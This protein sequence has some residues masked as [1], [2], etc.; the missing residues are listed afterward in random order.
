[1]HWHEEES[2]LLMLLVE[3]LIDLFKLVGEEFHHS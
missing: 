2:I 3:D 1:M